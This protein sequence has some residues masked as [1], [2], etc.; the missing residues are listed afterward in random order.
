MAKIDRKTFNE[1]PKHEAAR[2]EFDAMVED[3]MGRIIEK[4]K[5]GAPPA[6]KGFVAEFLEG[7]GFD[8]GEK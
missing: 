4:R 2:G 8:F 7:F 6:D 5:K 1:D 3:S